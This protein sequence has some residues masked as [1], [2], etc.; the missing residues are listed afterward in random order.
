MLRIGS[1]QIEM[2]DSDVKQRRYEI[3]TESKGTIDAYVI[4]CI[5]DFKLE[6]SNNL[7][8]IMQDVPDVSVTRLTD[9]VIFG[10]IA[11]AN[12]K[13]FVSISGIGPSTKDPLLYEMLTIFTKSGDSPRKRLN[14]GKNGLLS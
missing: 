6:I 8:V 9:G 2:L 14:P 5:G 7:S 13:Y 11:N 4:P 10:S 1:M 12:G 3:V